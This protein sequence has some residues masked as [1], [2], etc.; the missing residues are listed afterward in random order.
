[1]VWLT[2]ILRVTLRLFDSSTLRLFDS[3]VRSLVLFPGPTLSVLP[4]DILRVTVV[5]QLGG[6]PPPTALPHRRRMPEDCTS[7]NCTSL[8]GSHYNHPNTTNLHTHGLHVSPALG[9]DN[10]MD[11][12]I[13]P[14]QS[15]TYT[16]VIPRDH[17]A[18][19]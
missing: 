15:Y 17:M 8:M 19:P 1:V 16:Y 7:A 2:P 4:G 18:G 10:V 13:G 6:V 9:S 5:N 12:V 11:V 3:F 14:G